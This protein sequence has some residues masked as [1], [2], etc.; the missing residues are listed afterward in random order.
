MNASQLSEKICSSKLDGCLDTFLASAYK[1]QSQLCRYYS[2]SSIPVTKRWGNHRSPLAWD[3]LGLEPWSH[4]NYEQSPLHSQKHSLKNKLDRQSPYEKKRIHFHTFPNHDMDKIKLCKIPEIR[5]CVLKSFHLSYTNVQNK[6]SEGVTPQ[7]G[8]RS[9]PEKLEWWPMGTWAPFTDSSTRAAT[10]SCGQRISP[11]P[12][13]FTP[14]ICTD[15]H[16]ESMQIPSTINA[17]CLPLI[18]LA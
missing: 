4:Q 6:C 3:T 11:P 16:L 1:L 5:N 17:W 13:A 9:Y 10:K 2:R 15:L 14:N 18:Q 7:S 12:H 8:R